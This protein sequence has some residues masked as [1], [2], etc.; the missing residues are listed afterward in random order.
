MAVISK[1]DLMLLLGDDLDS[2]T[3]FLMSGDGAAMKWQFEQ[4]S[5][6]DLGSPLLQEKISLLAVAG[7]ISSETA[8]KILAWNDV[9]ATSGVP[10]P[11]TYRLF[12]IGGGFGYEILVAGKVVGS[13]PHLPALPGNDPMTENEANLVGDYVAKKITILGVRGVSAE[14]VLRLLSGVTA[15]ELIAEEQSGL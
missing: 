5:G 6:F 3:A 4:A 7:V 11:A 13:Q 8:G 9:N 15:D 14:N 2:F 10:M 1:S 12:S